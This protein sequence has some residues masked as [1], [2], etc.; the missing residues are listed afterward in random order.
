MCWAGAAMALIASI[1]AYLAASKQLTPQRAAFC[2]RPH[3]ALQI[4]PSD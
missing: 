3:A 4:M 2:L 1:L